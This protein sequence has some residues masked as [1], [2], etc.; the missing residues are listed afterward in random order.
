MHATRIY[1]N[2]SRYACSVNTRVRDPE[3]F[4]KID[5]PP[6]IHVHNISSTVSTVLSVLGTKKYELLR[7]IKET[8]SIINALDRDFTG[9]IELFK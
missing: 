3:Y 4:A 1:V 5:V 6:H 2:K 8:A 7:T 9:I